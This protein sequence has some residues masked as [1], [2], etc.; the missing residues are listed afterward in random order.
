MPND[1]EMPELPENYRWNVK[2]R[3]KASGLWVYKVTL[4]Q[5]SRPFGFWDDVWVRDSSEA[6]DASLIATATEIA[7]KYDDW[8][9]A[10]KREGI[11]YG[12]PEYREK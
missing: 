4:Q 5:K 3:K 12:N 9:T 10:K 2:L 8:L 7:D 1:F 6:T 11:Y